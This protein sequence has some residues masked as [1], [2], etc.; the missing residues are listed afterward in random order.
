M[1]TVMSSTTYPAGDPT[2]ERWLHALAGIGE[3]V[4]GDEPVAQLLDRVARTACTLPLR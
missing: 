4:G 1:L 3:A 2:L